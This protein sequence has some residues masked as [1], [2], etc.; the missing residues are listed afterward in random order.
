MVCG[1]LQTMLVSQAKVSMI[2]LRRW[3]SFTFSGWMTAK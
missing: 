3:A 2:L 1:T